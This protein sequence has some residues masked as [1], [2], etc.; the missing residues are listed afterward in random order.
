MVLERRLGNAKYANCDNHTTLKYFSCKTRGTVQHS[1]LGENNVRRQTE[2]TSM[3]MMGCVLRER[4]AR[5]RP[6]FH[7]VAALTSLS[8]PA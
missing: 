3:C 4:C 7:N 6:L 2:M 1:V 8:F 5:V